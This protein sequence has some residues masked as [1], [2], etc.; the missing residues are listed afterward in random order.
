MLGYTLAGNVTTSN[1]GCSGSRKEG[2][3]VK[4]LTK[5]SFCHLLA[6]LLTLL[7]LPEGPWI[8]LAGAE[9]FATTNFDFEY[10]TSGNGAVAPPDDDGDEDPP[11]S[12]PGSFTLPTGCDDPCDDPCNDTSETHPNFVVKLACWLEYSWDRYDTAGFDLPSGKVLVQVENVPNTGAW[13]PA[14]QR[15]EINPDQR[16]SSLPMYAAHELF[17]VVQYQYWTTLLGRPGWF[18]ESLPEAMAVAL[19]NDVSKPMFDFDPDGHTYDAGFLVFPPHLMSKSYK[20]WPMWSYVMEHSGSPTPVYPG[21][22]FIRQLMEN[23]RDNCPG[24]TLACMKGEL[25]IL[26]AAEGTDF[27][28]MMRRMSVANMLSIF[29]DTL[30]FDH[31]YGYRWDDV[32]N[33]FAGDVLDVMPGEIPLRFNLASDTHA[34]LPGFSVTTGGAQIYEDYGTSTVLAV[35]EQPAGSDRFSR[36]HDRRIASLLGSR[37]SVR[38]PDDSTFRHYDLP[39]DATDRW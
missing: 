27:P 39:G 24:R 30:D 28:T 16:M 2:N 8:S 22:N 12:L 14:A 7:G 1:Y 17:H 25:D 11:Y 19:T 5:L 26:L 38:G 32:I 36:Q 20:T 37:S 4:S 33:S 35:R 13:V 3:I 29:D 34:A 21:F 23:T 9:T 31:I 6:S 18:L 15:I 10:T